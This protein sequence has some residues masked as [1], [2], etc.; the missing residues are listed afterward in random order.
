MATLAVIIGAGL[1]GWAVL[2][3]AILIGERIADRMCR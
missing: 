3:V 1:L 2:H